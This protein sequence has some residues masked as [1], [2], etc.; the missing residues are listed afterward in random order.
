[1]ISFAIAD[2]RKKPHFAEVVADRVWRAFWKDDGHPLDLLTSLV[3]M[4]LESGPVPT[5]FVAHDGERFLGTV[6]LIACDEEARPQYTPWI[7]ALWVE[8]EARRQGIGAALVERSSQFAFSTG[9][10]RLY[11]LSR[12]R[13]RAYYEGIGWTML[14]AD[15]PEKGIH[16]LIRDRHE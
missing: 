1:M 5:A 12:E 8:P 3:Q 11:L 7:A 13:R 14:E 10:E 15:A 4:N 9:T 16:I 2:L 6:S